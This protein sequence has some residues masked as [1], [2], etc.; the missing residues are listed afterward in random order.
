MLP[1]HKQTE[2]TRNKQKKER[3]EQRKPS[4]QNTR[5]QLTR[6]RYSI[7][8]SADMENPLQ[9]FCDID[10]ETLLLAKYAL[11]THLR[12]N[13]WHWHESGPGRSFEMEN[14]IIK[15]FSNS[16]KAHSPNTDANTP[17]NAHRLILYAL[18]Q[19]DMANTEHKHELRC[20]LADEGYGT[21]PDLFKQARAQE[22]A[23]GRVAG[24]IPTPNTREIKLTPSDQI[25]D[26]TREKLEDSQSFLETLFKKDLSGQVAAIIIDTGTGKTEKGYPHKRRTSCYTHR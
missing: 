13:E 5:Q 15:P 4:K 26:I 24:I 6:C 11:A 20:K 23:S 1:K 19:L 21:H 12:G 10:P 14:G 16:I 2:S 17:V 18:H 7:S 22:R 8:P 9:V 3:A 25:S